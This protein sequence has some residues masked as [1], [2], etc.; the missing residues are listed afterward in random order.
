MTVVDRG[1]GQGGAGLGWEIRVRWTGWGDGEKA[2]Y[3]G[4]NR[5]LMYSILL[6]KPDFFKQTV[7]PYNEGSQKT[8]NICFTALYEGKLCSNIASLI[9]SM[10]LLFH[11]RSG[12]QQI[13]FFL[14][15]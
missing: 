13:L 9:Q 5:V 12:Q 2:G 10:F 8:L 11:F 1:V 6:F 15:V 3:G 4:G 14:L 7:L